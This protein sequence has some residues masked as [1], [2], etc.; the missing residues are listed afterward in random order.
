MVKGFA[1]RSRCGF[2]RPLSEGVS[3]KDREPVIEP[4]LPSIGALWQTLMAL[5]KKMELGGQIIFQDTGGNLF[6]YQPMLLEIGEKS[7]T[8]DQCPLQRFAFIAL[9]L[10]VLFKLIQQRIV[11]NGLHDVPPLCGASFERYISTGLYYGEQPARR[12][13]SELG[14]IKLLHITWSF[15]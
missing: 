10:Q 13:L 7:S 1:L 5:L 8:S 14:D 12:P 15:R 9:L 11:R 2:W 6:E 4:L 3:K